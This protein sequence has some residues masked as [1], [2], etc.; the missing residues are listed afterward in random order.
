[1]AAEGDMARLVATY[2]TSEGAELPA[3]T[4]VT[5]RQAKATGWS[6]VLHDSAL[7]WIPSS[8]LVADT[9]PALPDHS[10]HED[11]NASPSEANGA[12]DTVPTAYEQV[13][14]TGHAEILAEAHSHSGT[15][16]EEEVHH[17]AVAVGVQNNAVAEDNNDTDDSSDDED[18][19]EENRMQV[20]KRIKIRHGMRV[21]KA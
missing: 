2:T 16:K 20:R 10:T 3:N 14:G 8:W 9:P 4:C 18:D 12:G 6:L 15:Q 1:M 13:N 21:K 17:D 7:H 5:V 11:S 19:V